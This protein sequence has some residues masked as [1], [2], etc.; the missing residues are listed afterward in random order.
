MT[1]TPVKA[2]PLSVQ[3]AIILLVIFVSGAAAVTYG[4]A[5]LSGPMAPV[6]AGT[7]D[8][9]WS[10]SGL[11]HTDDQGGFTGNVY[12][13]DDDWWLYEVVH[14]HGSW[15]YRVPS[16]Q[17]EKE[18][19]QQYQTFLNQ[20]ASSGAPPWVS[21]ATKALGSQTT[22][23]EL[24]YAA[25]DARLRQ[26]AQDSPSAA[27]HQGFREY[28]ALRRAHKARWYWATLVFEWCFLVFLIGW[29]LW[30]WLRP[31]GP[32][33]PALYIAA[34]PLLFALPYYLGYAS[35]SLTSAGPSGGVLYPYLAIMT[36]GGGELY[37]IERWMLAHAPPLLDVLS[38]DIGEPLAITGR[39]LRGPITMLLYGA[40]A[41]V[42]VAGIGVW[43]RWRQKQ[44]ESK[45]QDGSGETSEP[46][47]Q[48]SE[49]GF[50]P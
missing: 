41:G 17:V 18:F 39:G 20:V 29:L 22:F 48:T 46:G 8:Q 25:R 21:E 37:A 40:A 35:W 5:R 36:L 16:D 24:R 30:P 14:I 1:T 9:F 19:A 6:K 10:A 28:S 33:R 31:S 2:R 26:L 44:S 38:H 23:T 11:A 34:A 15:L 49:R 42:I 3:R 27:I 45:T 7:M 50:K 12:Q 13:I 47:P 43:V 32:I 4:L